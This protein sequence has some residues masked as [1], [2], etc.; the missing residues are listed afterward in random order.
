[1]S[2]VLLSLFYRWINWGLERLINLY[3]LIMYLEKIKVGR[4]G[5]DG[6]IVHTFSILALSSDLHSRPIHW[7]LLH[8]ISYSIEGLPSV[9]LP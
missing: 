3:E 5:E 8:P 7:V 9:T 4:R 2:Y 6:H 1:M